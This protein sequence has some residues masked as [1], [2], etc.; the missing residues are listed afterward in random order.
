MKNKSTF[1]EKL[2][3]TQSYVV[4]LVFEAIKIWPSLLMF[5]FVCG[6][7]FHN[8]FLLYFWETGIHTTVSL[9]VKGHTSQTVCKIL[10]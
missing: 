9:I 2:Q 5:S 10:S 1:C 4:F 3:M 8:S 7:I 6:L